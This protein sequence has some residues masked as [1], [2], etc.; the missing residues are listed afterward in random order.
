[1]QTFFSTNKTYKNKYR[2]VYTK[3]KPHECAYKAQ[4]GNAMYKFPVVKSIG[5][6][7]CCL[8]IIF[9]HATSPRAFLTK[10]RYPDACKFLGFDPT[11]PDISTIS[12]KMQIRN[13]QE[14]L[15]ANPNTKNL[16][17]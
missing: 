13:K 3:T 17:I 10:V 1:M 9:A 11:L 14:E 12:F 16:I 7:F 5:C 15:E 8:S 4:K 2:S 6:L